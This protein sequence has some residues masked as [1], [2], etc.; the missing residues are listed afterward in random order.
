MTRK[1]K[2]NERRNEILETTMRVLAFEG[3]SSV[4]M[5][6]IADRL[7]ISLSNLQYY[8][9]TRRELLKSTIEKSIGTVVRQI[10]EMAIDSTTDPRKTL[11]KA[12]KIHL[13]ASRDPFISKFFAAIWALATYDKDAEELVNEIYERDCHRYAALIQ[14]ANPK[15]SKKTCETRAVLIVAQLEGLVLFIAPGK[16]RAAKARAIEKE[17]DSLIDTVVLNS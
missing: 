8:F 2:T 1:E 13:S 10:D 17:L 14:R 4:T 3:D 12:L 9:P 16:L 15:L 11:K 5:R 7:G 6:S